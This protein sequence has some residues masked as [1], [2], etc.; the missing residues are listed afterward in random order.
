[1]SLTLL[2]WLCFYLFIYTPHPL[3]S[4][5]LSSPKHSPVAYAEATR[6]KLFFNDMGRALFSLAHKSG[7]LKS[8]S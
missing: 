6:P 2:H 7:Y 1:M 3:V 8:H 5:S 4:L